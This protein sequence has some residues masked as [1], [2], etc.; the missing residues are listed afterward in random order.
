MDKIFIIILLRNVCVEQC[1]LVYS[2]LVTHLYLKSVYLRE[3]SR[4]P[5]KSAFHIELWEMLL[6]VFKNQRILSI[7]LQPCWALG[8]MLLQA[9]NFAECHALHTMYALCVCVCWNFNSNSS[10]VAN[11]RRTRAFVSQA[12]PEQQSRGRVRSDLCVLGHGLGLHSVDS[13]GAGLDCEEGQNSRTTTH[14]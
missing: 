1:A 12:T 2:V 10:S 5:K 4:R 14:I 6:Q 7:C 3:L 8:Q 13:G 9:I 11:L